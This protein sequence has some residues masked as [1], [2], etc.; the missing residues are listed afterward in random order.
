MMGYG[1]NGVVNTY[2][3]IGSC[4]PNL[5]NK[6]NEA[7]LEKLTSLYCDSRKFLFLKDWQKDTF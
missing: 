5:V 1:K 7:F 3:F 4:I 2:G 6:P